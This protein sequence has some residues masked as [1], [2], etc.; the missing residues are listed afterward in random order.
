MDN[1]AHSLIGIGVARCG[2]SR[3][4]GP[5]TTVTM[6]IAS[7]LPD[8]DAL[9]TMADPWDR[10]MLRRTHTHALVML[11]VLAAL[12]AV[13]LRWRYREQSWR[14]LFGLSLLGLGLHVAFD[15]VNAFGVVIFWP[16]S[17]RR[18]ELESVFIIDVLLWLLMLA[19]IAASRFL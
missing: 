16:F 7:N 15:L 4:F 17:M 18:V 13:A 19:P 1:L 3:R 10:F 9:W 5:G 2:L 6:V 11:P 12:L 8:I 14:T